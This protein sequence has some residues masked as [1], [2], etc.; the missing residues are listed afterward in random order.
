M[1]WKIKII[2]V[3]SS[4]V[5]YCLTS[6]YKAWVWYP[7]V[8]RKKNFLAWKTHLMKLLH[9]ALA[10]PKI[11]MG[12]FTPVCQLPKVIAW[13]LIILHHSVSVWVCM[14]VCPCMCLCVGVHM[15][16]PVLKAT[17]GSQVWSSIA[18]HLT[19]WLES[20]TDLGAHRF[21]SAG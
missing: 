19:F 2:W 7:S 12:H 20:S 11:S 9:V 10:S 17:G 18:C 15:C 8:W 16:V 21:G 5:D 3:H 1:S 13:I 6:I 14:W 4:I